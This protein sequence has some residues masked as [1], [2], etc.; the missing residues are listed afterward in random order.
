MRWR[1][2]LRAASNRWRSGG[3]GLLMTWCLGGALSGC[4]V[5]PA[6]GSARPTSTSVPTAQVA[7]VNQSGV[8]PYAFSP[9]TITVTVGTRVVWRNHSSQAHTVT[10]TGATPAFNSGASH[11]IRPGQSWSFVFRR[12]GRY[13][14]TCLLHP[15]MQGTVV[16][17]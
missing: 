17:R 10:D 4:A 13:V 6:S 12:P 3:I 5:L 9:A 2:C 15:Y 7:I 14:Y 16:V 1:R 11:L 8:N